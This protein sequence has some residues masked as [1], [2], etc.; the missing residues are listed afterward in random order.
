MS[1]EMTTEILAK[2]TKM[3]LYLN[4]ESEVGVIMGRDRVQQ[5][6]I[7]GRGQVLLDEKTKAIQYIYQ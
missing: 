6:S 2:A 5:Q 3:I 4:D 7:N 1:N